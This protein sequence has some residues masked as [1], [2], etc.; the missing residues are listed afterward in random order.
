MSGLIICGRRGKRGS[1]SP[2]PAP[3]PVIPV[4]V[5]HEYI[6][7]KY[8]TGTFRGRVLAISQMGTLLHLVV[9]DAMR[10]GPLIEDKCPYPECVLAEDHAGDHEF[11]KDLRNGSELEVRC[12]HIEIRPVAA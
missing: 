7:S 3:P 12:S 4:V 2:Q 8:W 6:V 1:R 5:G 9:T 10:P 11:S